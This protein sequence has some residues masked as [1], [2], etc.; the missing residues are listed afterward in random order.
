MK[1]LLVGS[2]GREHALA[3]K[4][5][6]SPRVT[7]LLVAPGNPGMAREPKVVCTGVAAGD[8]PGIHKICVDNGVAFVVVGPD[9]ALA[10]GLVDFLAER[11][12]RAF[13]PVKAAAKVEWSKAFSKE[14]MAERGIPT[15]KFRV[16]ERLENAE[17][18][19][20]GVEWGDGWVVKAD[21][22]ALGKGVVV[23]QSREEALA[24][25]RDFLGGGAMGEAGKRVVI[26]ERLPGREV[27]AFSLCDGERAVFLG[28]ACD[29]KRIFD[30][31]T[32]P[33][34]GGMGAFSPADWLPEGT[35]ER[36]Q[37]EVV[38]PLLRALRDRGTPFRGILFTGLMVTEKGPK[39]I[40]FNARFGDPETQVILPLLE[41]D[42]LPWLEAAADGALDRMPAAGPLL[43]LQHA[44]HVVMAAHGYPG[45]G[46]AKV[47]K[48][49]R[50]EIPA[51]LGGVKLFVAG[52]EE[53]D[54]AFYTNGG[55]V[56]GVTA[57]GR[58]RAEAREQAFRASD[59]VKFA[60]SQRRE[61]VGK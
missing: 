25:V 2:G 5:A 48:G 3:W 21:G 11:G 38:A 56:L 9:Q 51:N 1:L 61:D 26:E 19:L 37:A 47:R 23:A 41:D 6:Q 55:R 34:T 44:V 16:F 24:T 60:G 13:G 15:A 33:N 46:G 27:S 52:V 35:A 58:S 31:D 18:F 29:Y 12:V 36:V 14:L 54:G 49:D 4:L 22:L 7:E 32:G 20:K 50:I 40:E 43:K 57:L 53:R 17:G 45:A 30:G 8:F 28:F 59:Q 10:D 42:L 39:V